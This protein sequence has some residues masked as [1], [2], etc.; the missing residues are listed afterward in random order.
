MAVSFECVT[1]MRSRVATLCMFICLFV[2]HFFKTPLPTLLPSAL[3]SALPSSLSPFFTPSLPPSFCAHNDARECLVSSIHDVD[4]RMHIKKS[5]FLIHPL[6]A[7]IILP[8]MNP[9]FPPLFPL[10]PSPALFL[11]RRPLS[12]PLY[13]PS[14]PRFETYVLHIWRDRCKRSSGGCIRVNPTSQWHNYSWGTLFVYTV[15]LYLFSASSNNRRCR[16]ISKA[17]RGGG[18]GRKGGGGVG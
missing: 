12:F 1:Q 9:P 11:L 4:N 13:I 14:D 16:L 6:S 7:S 5:T 8:L 17:M 2:T 3:P 15:H 10:P 18:D